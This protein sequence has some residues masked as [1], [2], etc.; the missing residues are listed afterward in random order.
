MSKSSMVWV[1]KLSSRIHTSDLEDQFSKYGK[2]RDV[3]FR[4]HRGFA[5]IEYKN[6]EDA[7]Y[8]IE[9]MDGRY[10]EGTR[11]VVEFKG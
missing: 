6:R 10:F 9:K 4:K 1:G 2:I 8:A 5:F 3:D 11:I 7:K